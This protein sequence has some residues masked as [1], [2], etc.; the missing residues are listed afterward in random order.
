MSSRFG[1]LIILALVIFS[2]SSICAQIIY[3]GE[4]YSLE[5]WDQVAP[6]LAGEKTALSPVDSI[7]NN[8]EIGVVGEIDNHTLSFIQTDSV[9]YPKSRAII[10][11]PD[12]FDITTF[13]KIRYDDN[14][15]NSINLVI[16]TTVISDNTFLIYF[17]DS[18]SIPVAGSLVGID[19]EGITNE[20]ES[21][22]YQLILTLTD[23]T[24]V[25]T[26]GPNFSQPFLLS[27]GELNSIEVDPSTLQ[28]IYAGDFFQFDCL[29]SDSFNNALECPEETWYLDDPAGEIDSTGLFLAKYTGF[30]DFKAKCDAGGITAESG[31]LYVLAGDPVRF[32]MD[33]LP[34]TTIVAG[35]ILDS[36]VHV[37]VEDL[38]GN[39]VGRYRGA[40][41]FESSDTAAE[42]LYDSINKYSFNEVDD[43]QKYFPD[44]A[45]IF[46]TAGQQTIRIT[47]GSISSEYKY[48]VVK[49]DIAAH[50]T[51]QDPSDTVTA[52]E[53][54]LIQI[55]SLTDVS[56]NL[57]SGV[58]DVQ[59]SG[60]GIAPDG[61]EPIINP[62]FVEAGSGQASQR[63]PKAGPA[64]FTLTIDTLIYQLDT[65]RVI[66]SAADH[67]EFE[68]NTPQT[69]G[70]SFA[71]PA[72]LT[73]LDRFDNVVSDFNAFE[74]TVTISPL[75]PAEGE[76]I[77]GIIAD[78]QAFVDGVCDLTQFD[79]YYSGPARFL[80]FSAVSQSGVQ[81]NSETVE[82]NSAL[83]EQLYLSDSTLYIGDTFSASVT[84][85]N[86]G[87]DTLTVDTIELFS[88]QGDLPVQSAIPGPGFRI[89]GNSSATFE[90]YSFIPET[91][92]IGIIEFGASFIGTYDELTISDTSEFLASMR[93]L[94]QELADYVPGSLTPV[95]MTKGG[96][97]SAR[98]E[99][100][101]LGG[102]VISLNT[103]SYLD[104]ILDADT[105][106]TYLEV[107]TFLPATGTE[108]V[109]FFDEIML[110]G[111]LASGQYAAAL[112][113]FGL[114]GQSSYSDLVS[115][116]DSITLQS[117]PDL[118][119]LQGSFGPDSA[120]LGTEIAPVL[121]VENL[122]EAV[123][124]IDR[125]LS[126]LELEA[127]GRQVIFRPAVDGDPIFPG[128]NQ[129]SFDSELVPSDSLLTSN[130]LS[131][132]LEGT[133]NQQNV[134]FDIE[135]G[136]D[137]LTLLNPGKVQIWS[138]TNR[139]PNSPRVN[140]GQSFNITVAARN[141]GQEAV[142][143]IRLSLQGEGSTVLQSSLTIPSL[144]PDETDSVT[145]NV[146]ASGTPNIAEVFEASIDN[147]FGAI[148]GLPA[149]VEN[150]V[151]NNTVATVELPASISANLQIVSPP[152]ALDNVLG[153][154][155]DFT[156]QAEFINSGDAKVSPG[157]ARLILP[158]GFVTGDLLDSVD[159]VIGDP[160]TWDITAPS[161][162]R[163]TELIV[164]IVKLPIDSNS[165][166]SALVEKRTDTLAV[167]VEDELPQT[168]VDWQFED[169]DLVY[170]GQTLPVVELEFSP[171]IL[172]TSRVL[173]SGMTFLFTDRQGRAFE[174]DNLL[175]SGTIS[176]EQLEYPGT[177]SS[178]T[179]S[180]NFGDGIIFD[181]ER[182]AVLNLEIVIDDQAALE[183]F[184]ISL[185]SDHITAND[186]R[187]EVLGSPLVVKS[188]DGGAFAISK[189]Y[190]TVQSEFENSFYNYPNPFNP[191]VE[192]TSI[193][194]YLPSASDVDLTIYT[195][196]GEEVF[197]TSIPAGSPGA[198]GGTINSIYWDG[199]N[200]EALE[201]RE[202][203]Y[204][205]VVKYSGGEAWTKIAVVK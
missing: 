11:F 151:D 38:Y 205:A 150:P 144:A 176:Y 80:K 6:G 155:Q 120:Y 43:G 95:L 78:S 166:D 165:L 183:N 202:G 10:T 167:T 194:Y 191:D 174:L 195:L 85:S 186:Y 41:W 114:Q 13:T 60:D 86:F 24:G 111:A 185:D 17:A 83:I 61:T 156:L 4:S 113:L 143:E 22:S 192:A 88:S 16:D 28:E 71:A 161:T 157:T 152:D 119:Y 76:V 87:S 178:N 164:E 33:G 108:V 128:G 15:I 3:G 107:P 190:G 173:L 140:T 8:L 132:H 67:I 162:P 44:S 204:L 104:F 154:K 18:G 66:N 5:E 40:A 200:D 199:R 49:P 193:V 63:L 124:E 2:P 68:L 58:V 91:F 70:Q 97:Y 115:I 103:D 134:A 14:D 201:V 180:F 82:I 102:A 145:F 112:H 188:I 131:L 182:S 29:C 133:A 187:F 69:V 21:G 118:V 39:E 90:L 84:I 93:I 52:G 163:E 105:F 175:L 9:M 54:F 48:I 45:F 12:G 50:I 147:A 101:N 20:T 92:E 149:F 127:D 109:L 171:G 146:T 47:D 72:S 122:G 141:R 35:K 153:I 117:P 59:L 42:L 172:S 74:D 160:L 170:P 148:T 79:M 129:I 31:S 7:V 19:M 169:Y 65:I 100:Q 138:T 77:N 136:P 32:N 139:A 126:R 62:I 130:T 73:V 25:V 158:E 125:Q 75:P 177:I 89:Q 110:P 56:G 46:H 51:V 53:N 57:L 34:D 184:I 94:S 1:L 198:Q 137:L 30:N 179:L 121:S 37:I 203:V 23:S 159:F 27:P 135:I 189:S 81:G 168:F 55:T 123:F 106:R 99:L 36:S 64:N 116:S 196:I 142:E 98:L 181:A 96:S 197:T 26:A